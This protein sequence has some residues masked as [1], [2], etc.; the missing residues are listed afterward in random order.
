[1]TRFFV[2]PD[3]IVDSLATLNEADAYHLRVVLKSAIGEPI[4]ILDDSGLEFPGRLEQIGKTHATVRLG[5]PILAQT[6]PAIQI[7]VAQA[8][9][10]MA[11][12]MEQVL[13]HATE[14][15][16]VGF[17]A[18]A[19]ERSLTQLAG[20]RQAKRMMRWQTII[21]TAAEQAHRAK[22]PSLRS[23]GTLADVL[24]STSLFDLAILAHTE[25]AITLREALGES[26]PKA[27]LVVVGPESGFTAKEAAGAARS[28]AKL[29]SLGPRILRAETAALTAVSQL[30]YALESI[31]VR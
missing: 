8:L 11:E 23:D 13:Q 24:A 17:W 2:R 19:S 31:H 6:E 15:G 1:M 5:E 29:I 25:S 3:Q 4:T 26:Q 16:A 12:K 7:T 9:P 10:K 30:L 18:F 27:I 28:G 14:I 22:M 20:E 21:K